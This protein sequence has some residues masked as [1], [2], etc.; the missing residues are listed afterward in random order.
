VISLANKKVVANSEPL[1]EGEQSDRSGDFCGPRG[2]SPGGF[3]G[4]PALEIE[5]GKTGKL[6]TQAVRSAGVCRYCGRD[7]S[8]EELEHIRQL[9]GLKPPLNRVQ[10]SVRVCQDL[11]W[12]NWAGHPKQ[13]SCRVALLRMEKDG[14][15]QLPISL[16]RGANLRTRPLLTSAS[17]PRAAVREPVGTL[18]PLHFQCVQRQPDSGLWNELMERHHY[19]GY[20]PLSGAQ[21]RYL[22]RSG[23]GR[24]LA[25]LGFGASA[26]H[27]KPR[28][29]YIGWDDQQRRGHLHLIVNNAR[30]LI[31]PWVSS[32]GLASRI[33]SGMISP[34][35]TDWLL[36]YAYRPVL[37]ETFVESPSFRGTSYKAA[38]WIWVGQTQ[39]RG[40][41]E[42][43]HRRV[44]P[45][46]QIWL[47]P[48]HPNFRKILRTECTHANGLPKP[49]RG[50]RR[51]G[52]LDLP[53]PDPGTGSPELPLSF[54]EHQ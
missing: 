12:L 40:K 39:G 7:F 5:R 30:F 25:A 26:W 43:E 34:L 9:L 36:R 11:G 41:L 2:P 14:L 32:A 51:G 22:I 31:L 45:V 21:M 6:A 13:M 47:Y 35:L 19:L 17:A 52:Q 18:E 38:N 10:L 24:L 15:L 16:S 1:A 48:L 46:K 20:C 49:L 50:L 3:G 29:Q 27:T 37:L 53:G 42:Q 33:L 54:D 8:A 4:V 23:D 28:D 44:C